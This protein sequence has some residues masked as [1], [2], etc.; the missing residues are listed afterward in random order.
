[1][2]GRAW[3]LPLSTLHRPIRGGRQKPQDFHVQA[4]I[5]KCVC[6]QNFLVPLTS[7]SLPVMR[8]TGEGQP[9]E[10]RK[11]V[12][13]PRRRYC[14]YT[15]FLWNGGARRSQFWHAFLRILRGCF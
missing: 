13:Y 6:V 2:C 5:S 9:Y 3:G 4:E 1:M 14:Y 10:T 7:A 8:F 15:S 12:Q 11:G